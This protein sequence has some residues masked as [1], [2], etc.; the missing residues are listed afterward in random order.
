MLQTQ[1]SQVV[2][3]VTPPEDPTSDAATASRPLCIIESKKRKK[4][5]KKVGRKRGTERPNPMVGVL[6]RLVSGI[7]YI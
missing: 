5:R 6:T 1:I 2:G 7:C 4:K 3:T